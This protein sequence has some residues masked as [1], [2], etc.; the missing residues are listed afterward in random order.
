MPRGV[1][2]EET[3]LEKSVSTLS[4]CWTGRITGSACSG[5]DSHRAPAPA[6]T[7]KV[8]EKRKNMKCRRRGYGLVGHATTV[9][10]VQALRFGLLLP[11]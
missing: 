10:A 11:G 3:L 6:V 9:A 7:D 2:G 5:R 1:D 8:V 4:R